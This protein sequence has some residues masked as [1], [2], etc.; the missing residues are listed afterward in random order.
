MSEEALRNFNKWK[1]SINNG[2]DTFLTNKYK[3]HNVRLSNKAVMIRVVDEADKLAVQ[4][5]S[6]WSQL[7]TKIQHENSEI[8][9]VMS[10]GEKCLGWN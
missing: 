7:S 4:Q 2:Y 10:A 6:I 3:D 8:L 9:K 5:A 1:Q